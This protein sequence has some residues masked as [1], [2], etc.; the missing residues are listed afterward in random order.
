MAKKPER[1]TTE[2]DIK[3]LNSFSS[4]T[5]NQIDNDVLDSSKLNIEMGELREDNSNLRLNLFERNK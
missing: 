4:S 1:L 5:Q 2:D 3:I